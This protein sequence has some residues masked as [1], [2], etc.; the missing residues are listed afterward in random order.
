M[1]HF[2]MYKGPGARSFS[3]FL[4]LIAYCDRCLAGQRLILNFFIGHPLEH[5]EIFPLP[6]PLFARRLVGTMTLVR[7]VQFFS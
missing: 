1:T 2:F 5:V 4:A 6:P 3:P 7:Y